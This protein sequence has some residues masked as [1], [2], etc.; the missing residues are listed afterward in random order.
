MKQKVKK[1]KNKLL[2]F[3]KLVYYKKVLD[4]RNIEYRFV[5]IIPQILGQQC[6]ADD[7]E[8]QV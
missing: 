2:D 3:V 7:L 4:F 6:H 5:F 1:K 8:T